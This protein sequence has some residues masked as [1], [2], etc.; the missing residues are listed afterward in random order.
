[1]SWS[2]VTLDTEHLAGLAPIDA[3]T[4]KV[5][6]AYETAAKR[7]VVSE[8]TRAYGTDNVLY[9]EDDP[10]AFWDLVADQSSLEAH[11]QDM[12]CFAFLWT[13]LSQIA[14][15]EIHLQRAKWARERF[16]MAVEAF[17]RY[18]PPILE[19][20]DMDDGEQE[21]PTEQVTWSL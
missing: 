14:S 18:A 7:L 8:V 19:E 6:F 11:V 9:D 10:D 20:A 17:V 2:T 4:V 5:T 12:I 15:G 21:I 13:Y 16:N 1:M 3:P